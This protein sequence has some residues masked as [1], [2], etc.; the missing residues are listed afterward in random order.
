MPAMLAIVNFRARQRRVE[1][2]L[3]LQVKNTH[4]RYRGVFY[5]DMLPLL[6]P[7]SYASTTACHITF[8]AITI[9]P[10]SDDGTDWHYFGDRNLARC[11]P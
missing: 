10:D 8:A 4:D 2:L 6:I 11:D 9:Q 7:Y 1:P 3:A 5:F